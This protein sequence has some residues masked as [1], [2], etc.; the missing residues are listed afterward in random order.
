VIE[1]LNI[2][3]C[4]LFETPSGA[5]AILRCILSP[6]DDVRTTAAKLLFSNESKSNNF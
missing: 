6:T 1:A 3:E 5:K 4:W 2:C